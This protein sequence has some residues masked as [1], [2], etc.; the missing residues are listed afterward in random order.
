MNLRS[1]LNLVL[2][3]PAFF[4]G[5]YTL[6]GIT[7]RVLI[8]EVYRYL[9]EK[10]EF[11]WKESL[12]VNTIHSQDFCS[13]AVAV[14]NWAHGKSRSELSSTSALEDLPSTLKSDQTVSAIPLAAR[15]TESCAAPV[16]TLVDDGDVTQSKI[17][18]VIESVVGVPTSFVGTLVSQFAKM[19][20]SDVLEDVNDKH[21]QGWS[22]LLT[23]SDPPISTT[24]PISATT[25]SLGQQNQS[26]ASML[27][28]ELSCTAGRSTPTLP[29]AVQQLQA[30]RADRLDT[31]S[32]SQRSCR[33]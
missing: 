6:T 2:L 29:S 19:N 16:F 20:M 14:A 33:A 21:A 4:Y 22:D 3:R 7:P 24:V 5:P 17:A 15:K 27:T 13:A 12:A 23:A 30:Q 32:C 25:V 8:G 31:S 1:S 9:G 26:S 10:L 28:P 18:S 11:L